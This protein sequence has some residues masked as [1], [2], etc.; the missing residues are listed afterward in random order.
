[1]TNP[2]TKALGSA[3]THSSLLRSG[4]MAAMKLFSRFSLVYIAAADPL[5]PSNNWKKKQKK[6]GLLY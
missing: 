2:A 6:Q 4:G 5:C 1:L 3:A